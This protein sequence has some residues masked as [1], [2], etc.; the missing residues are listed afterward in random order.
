MSRYQDLHADYTKRWQVEIDH[1]NDLSNLAQEVHSHFEAYL[2]IDPGAMVEIHGNNVPV[3]EIG[4]LDLN[5]EFVAAAVSDLQRSDR[6]VEVALRLN[7]KLATSPLKT[8]QRVFFFTLAHV[9]DG[10][11]AS[12]TNQLE[13][14]DI[15]CPPYKTLFDYLLAH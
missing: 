2:G 1:W 8:V 7:F 10:F 6:G 11:S 15:P 12:V 4:R 3:L 14:I 13:S 5:R 9:G